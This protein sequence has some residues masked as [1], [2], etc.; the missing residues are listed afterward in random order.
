M[1]LFGSLTSPFVRKA[2]ILIKE[3]NLPCEFV[4]ADPT[5]AGGVVRMRNPLW[6]VPVLETD[7]GES[8]FD[9]PVIVEY[10][11]SLSTPALLAT[12][13]APRWQILRWQALADGIMEAVIARFLEG[14]RPI[15]QQSSDQI[16]F[17]EARVAAA[18][19]F[20]SSRL[21]AEQFLLEGRFTLADLALAVALEY[22]DFRYPHDWRAQHPRLAF[23]LAGISVRASFVETVPPGMERPQRVPN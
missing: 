9:S 7:D 17:Q 18:L 2:R 11:D 20:A 13:G 1:K 15:V 10:L 23:W 6:Q 19:A 5:E 21:K 12:S 3:K 14:R 16:T 22:T 4:V 8:L